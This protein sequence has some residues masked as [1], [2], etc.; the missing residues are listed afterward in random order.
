MR[1]SDVAKDF[2]FGRA[3]CLKSITLV[4][5]NVCRPAVLSLYTEQ[6]AVLIQEEVTVNKHV[7]SFNVTCL[8]S[9]H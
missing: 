7:S 1:L 2:L 8:S 5:L 9:H 4:L 3:D 6:K